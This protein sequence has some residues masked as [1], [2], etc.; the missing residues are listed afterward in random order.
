[1]DTSILSILV[2]LVTAL[3]TAVPTY[4]GTRYKANIELQKQRERHDAEIRKIQEQ[5][6]REIEKNKE[7]SVSQAD[8]YEKQAQ[9]DM[10]KGFMEKALSGDASGL[11]NLEK[12]NKQI[13][14]SKYKNAKHPAKKRK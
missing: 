13:K 8:L 12:L 4:L 9:T 2:P 10:V 6:Q 3:I 11:D 14:K 7:E 5:A 1:M